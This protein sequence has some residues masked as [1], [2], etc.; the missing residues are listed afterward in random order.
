MVITKKFYFPNVLVISLTTLL[1]ID[2]TFIIIFGH[3]IIYLFLLQ[4]REVATKDEVISELSRKT[5]QVKKLEG[6]INGKLTNI[7]N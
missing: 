5:E 1:L 2:V 7:I 6:K 3:T 4:F